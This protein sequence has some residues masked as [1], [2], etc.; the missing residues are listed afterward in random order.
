MNIRMKSMKAT[1]AERGQVTIP[2][3]LRDRLGMRPGTTLEFSEKGGRLVAVKRSPAD[4]VAKLY[5][6]LGRKFDTDA[7]ITKI[8]GPRR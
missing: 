7:F 4:P 6:C 3:P 5:G 1:V 2:K 8:R